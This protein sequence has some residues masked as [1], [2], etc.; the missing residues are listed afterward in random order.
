M[1]ACL[2]AA[3]A[4]VET[5]PLRLAEIATPRPG[6]GEV[7]V[8]VSACGVCRTDLHVV[9]GELAP[10]KSP[11]IPG[12]QVVGTVEENGDGASRFSLGA[13]VG[14]PWLHRT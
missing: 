10:R 2:L 7:R 4:P 5:K 8:R 14:V 13:R 6:A 3:P 1:K 11:V 9:E 12:H